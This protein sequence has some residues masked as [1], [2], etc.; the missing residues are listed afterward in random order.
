MDVE[1]AQALA[2][3]FWPSRA[4][5]RAR[6]VLA[7]LR[8]VVLTGPPEM[9][10]TAIAQM[11]ALLRTGAP[12][13]S[14]TVRARGGWRGSLRTCLPA[15]RPGIRGSSSGCAPRLGRQR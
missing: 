10:K 15:A 11:L 2:R 6:D 8:F 14:S 9:G 12:Q 3:V 1:R 13:R 4:Y 5:E 7:R